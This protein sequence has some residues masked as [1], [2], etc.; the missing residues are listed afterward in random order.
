MIWHVTSALLPLQHS[1][2]MLGRKHQQGLNCPSAPWNRTGLWDGAAGT[3]A[4]ERMLIQSNLCVGV[5][6][7]S[8]SSP[9]IQDERNHCSMQWHSMYAWH[10][11]ESGSFGHLT[12]EG[13]KYSG[14]SNRGRERGTKKNW[15]KQRGLHG[16]M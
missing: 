14:Q 16:L 4:L 13:S 1:V 7:L 15:E 3:A 11:H 6:I 2:S 8:L 10:N 9:H 5:C 12:R